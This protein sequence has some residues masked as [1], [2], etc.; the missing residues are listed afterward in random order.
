MHHASCIMHAE[1]HSHLSLDDDETGILKAR[2]TLPPVA[3]P[4]RLVYYLSS[5]LF[6]FMRVRL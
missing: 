5:F 4:G 6:R 3:R 2:V 1:R